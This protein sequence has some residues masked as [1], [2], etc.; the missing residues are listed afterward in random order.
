MALKGARNCE[1]WSKRAF[2]MLKGEVRGNLKLWRGTDAL[3]Q[4]SNPAGVPEQVPDV[5]NKEYIWSFDGKTPWKS[6][7]ENTDEVAFN[8]DMKKTECGFETCEVG[9]RERLLLGLV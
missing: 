6:V 1:V 9:K 7:A 4:R 5:G 3:A 2:E 8:I